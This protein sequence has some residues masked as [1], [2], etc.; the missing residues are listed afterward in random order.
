MVPI[1]DFVRSSIISWKWWTCLAL[2]VLP[3]I[4]WL[5]YDRRE[6]RKQ[7]FYAGAVIALIS[8]ILDALGV[9]LGYW[10]YNVQLLPI[11]IGILPYDFTLIP[12]IIMFMIKSD[13]IKQVFIKGSLFSFLTTY[14]GH[15]LF[16]QWLHFVNHTHWENSLSLPIYLLLYIIANWL[17]LKFNSLTRMRRV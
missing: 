2:S 15:P 16:D 12:V 4:L 7:R 13:L 6:Y 1:E 9:T 8:C 17:F 5:I 3:W 14:I 11:P 10:K